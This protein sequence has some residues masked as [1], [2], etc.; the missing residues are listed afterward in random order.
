METQ[1]TGDLHNQEDV[2]PGAQLDKIIV[3]DDDSSAPKTDGTG[4]NKPVQTEGSIIITEDLQ[5]R[6]SDEP[7][8]LGVDLDGTN[9][10]ANEHDED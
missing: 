9:P 4:S 7:D 5:E 10:G 6:L 8:S 3:T 2:N 1:E